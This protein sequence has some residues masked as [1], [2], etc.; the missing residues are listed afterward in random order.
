MRSHQEQEQG[1]NPLSNHERNVAPV[2]QSEYRVFPLPN[3]MV[4][5][6]LNSKSESTEDSYMSYKEAEDL[7]RISW[8]ELMNCIREN[9]FEMVTVEEFVL[10]KRSSVVEFYEFSREFL[11]EWEQKYS[12]TYK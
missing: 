6:A 12:Q 10:P 9:V 7:L 4:E 3:E 5:R 1:A 2:F 8:E 11:K